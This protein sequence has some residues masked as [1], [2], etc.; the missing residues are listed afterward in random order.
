MSWLGKI[1][2]VNSTN[3]TITNKQNQY[4]VV[5]FYILSVALLTLCYVKILYGG[6]ETCVKY[7]T[8]CSILIPISSSLN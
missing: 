6:E 7:T 1:V 5:E 4:L 8:I 3:E 2:P